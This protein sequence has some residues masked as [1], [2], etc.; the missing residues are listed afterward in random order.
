MYQ[1]CVDVSFGVPLLDEDKQ[2]CRLLDS[3]YFG[4]SRYTVFL[5]IISLVCSAKYKRI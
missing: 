3:R 2:E 5:H 4:P 1:V